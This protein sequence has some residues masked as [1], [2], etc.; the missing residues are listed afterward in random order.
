MNQ[1]DDL[2]VVGV[3][4]AMSSYSAMDIQHL[5]AD[6]FSFTPFRKSFVEVAALDTPAAADSCTAC[7][8]GTCYCCPFLVTHP[9]AKSCFLSFPL[10][11]CAVAQL[12]STH[13]AAVN[14]IA[15]PTAASLWPICCP[16]ATR[17]GGLMPSCWLVFLDLLLAAAEESCNCFARCNASYCQLM[18]GVTLPA[19]L[20]PISE[21]L[22]IL[23]ELVPNG[24][25]VDLVTMLEKAIS[26]VKFF[27]TASEGVGNRR[28][29]AS[30]RRKSTGSFPSKRSH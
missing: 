4:V 12:C 20:V 27:S 3:G 23:Q 21:R 2:S 18:R 30:S 26:Y 14:M 28:V 15:A 8:Y 19:E 10:L 5:K 16:S 9:A 29:L 17:L 6:L 24:S 1:R 25:K 22:K 7:C 13:L 11:L